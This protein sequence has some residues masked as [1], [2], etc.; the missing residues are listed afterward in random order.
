MTNLYARKLEKIFNNVGKIASKGRD[1]KIE[2]TKYIDDLI[3]KGDFSAFQEMLTIFYQI[4]T[5]NMQ[6]VAEIKS[7]TW[8]EICFQTKTPFMAKL[9]KLYNATSYLQFPTYINNHIMFIQ[10]LLRNF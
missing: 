4:E 7:K 5:L 3:Q 8:D 6:D 2:Y 9:S 10:I 1:N